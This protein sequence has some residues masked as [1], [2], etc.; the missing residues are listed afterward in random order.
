MEQYSFYI[1][2]YGCQMNVSDSEI[3][4]SIL[5]SDGMTAASLDDANI[6]LLNTCS[7]RDNAEERVLN[8][9]DTLHHILRKRKQNAVIGVIGCMAERLKDKLFDSLN[10]VS[11]VVGPDEYKKL[12]ELARNALEG[13]NGLAI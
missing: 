13:H 8:R 9:I 5:L 2:T 10:A 1:E 6:I 12:P 3:V 4:K 11:I 7:V